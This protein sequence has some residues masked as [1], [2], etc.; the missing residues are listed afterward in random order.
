[1]ERG[2]STPLRLG[3]LAFLVSATAI[4]VGLGWGHSLSGQGAPDERLQLVQRATR[5]LPPYKGVVPQPLAA[6]FLGGDSRLAVAWFTTHETPDEVIAFY[7]EALSKT[8]ASVL[9][10]RYNENV[11]YVGFRDAQAGELHLVSVIA[12]GGETTVL[13]SSGREGSQPEPLWRQLP[14][15]IPL[16]PDA[17]KPLVMRFQEEGQSRVSVMVDAPAFQ[18]DQVVD[19]YLRELRAQGWELEQPAERFEG[20]A[21]LAARSGVLRLSVLIQPQDPGTRLYFELERP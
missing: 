3:E 20:Q 15:E 6:D 17:R 8:Q 1:M 4:P 13:L 16:P 2:F 9:S 18:V 19:F 11:G 12:Q 5:E 7:R 10:Y 14:S 21:F